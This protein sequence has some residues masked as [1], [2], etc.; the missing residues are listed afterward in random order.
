MTGERPLLM[1]I[2]KFLREEGMAATSFGRQAVRDPRFVLDLRMGRV[3]GN[4]VACRVEHFMNKY[5]AEAG[6]VR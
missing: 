3:P 2:E 1:R 4:F 6:A 5:R